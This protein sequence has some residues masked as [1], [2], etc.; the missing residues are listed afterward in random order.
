MKSYSQPEL[1]TFVSEYLSQ[2]EGAQLQDVL[3]N[4]RGLALGFWKGGGLWLILDLHPN[5][6]L[7][8]VYREECPFRKAP[9]GKP[10]QLFLK[11]HGVN[12]IFQGAEVL[13]EFGR[14]LRFKLSSSEGVCEV[15]IHLIPRQVNVLVRASGKQISWERPKELTA[16]EPLT[17]YPPPRDL[18]QIHEQWKRPSADPSQKQDP[19]VQWQKKKE[20]DLEKKR[21]ALVELQAQAESREAELWFERGETLKL[22]EGE[23]I[24][25]EQSLAW[26]IE[27]AFARGKKLQKKR[28]GARERVILLEEEISQLEKLS[29]SEAQKSKKPQGAPKALLHQSKAKGRTLHLSDALT[30]FVGKSATDNLA[31][32]RKARA[33]DLWLHLRDEPG[34]HAILQRDKNRKVSDEELRQVA[35]WLVKESLRQEPMP[36]ERLAVVVTECRHVRPIRGDR[37]GRVTYHEARHFDLRWE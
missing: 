20:R 11:S 34:A 36:G 3:V 33:W 24:D 9:K 6:P 4:D 32:L 18:A 23:W 22:G 31:L 29:F 12:K 25:P 28:E 8:L 2:L 5:E 30:A 26:N 27:E 15:E 19:A 16:Q 13:E 35:R 1:R 7:A 21:K 37:L 10:L 17:E 14:V